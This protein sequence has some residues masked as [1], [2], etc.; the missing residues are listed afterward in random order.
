MTEQE[1]NLFSTVGDSA[2]QTWF[3]VQLLRGTIVNRANFFVGKN[4]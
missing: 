1:K 4:S 2:I 3:I